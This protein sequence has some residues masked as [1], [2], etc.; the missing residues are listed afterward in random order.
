MDVVDLAKHMYKLLRDREQAIAL[1]LGYGSASN[2]EHYQSLV[3]EI[4]GLAFAREELKALLENHA[5]DVEDI[6]SS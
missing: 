2:W 5:D 3:G 1:D 6:I 4:R